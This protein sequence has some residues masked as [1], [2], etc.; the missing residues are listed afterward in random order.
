VARGDRD[1]EQ[2]AVVDTMIALHVNTHGEEQR[3]LAAIA[4][5][6]S[7]RECRPLELGI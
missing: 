6:R 1:A 5:G 7:T 4:S 3:S 2:R